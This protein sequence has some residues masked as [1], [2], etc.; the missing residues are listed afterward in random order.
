[1]DQTTTIVVL[2]I[3]WFDNDGGGK[4]KPDVIVDGET[5]RIV[6]LR[7]WAVVPRRQLSLSSLLYHPLE[8]AYWLRTELRGTIYGR[9]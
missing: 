2:T 8:C 7:Q 3:D 5:F 4:T 6:E 1:M 9:I